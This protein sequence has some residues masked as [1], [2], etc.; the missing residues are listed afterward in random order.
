MDRAI[1]AS[2]EEGDPKGFHVRH[3]NGVK[4]MSQMRINSRL[5]LFKIWIQVDVFTLHSL[6]F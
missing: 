3:I 4:G 2:R 6:M 5:K 1:S